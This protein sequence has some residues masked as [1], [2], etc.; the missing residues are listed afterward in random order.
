M[1]CHNK[2]F[3][4]CF[5]D[6][7]CSVRVDYAMTYIIAPSTIY[8]LASGPLVDARLQ[9]DH[10]I[11]IP[12]MLKLAIWKKQTPMIGLGKHIW[13]SVHIDDST[14]VLTFCSYLV[15][16]QLYS[17]GIHTAQRSVCTYCYSTGSSQGPQTW[18]TGAKEYTLLRMASTRDL[19][20]VRP[21]A[22]RS[23]NAGLFL[24]RSQQRSLH[25][26]SLP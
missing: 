16:E 14:S 18:D 2:P 24:V 1:V 25:R 8:G 19:K 12:G 7:P 17:G 13:P 6:T 9:N 26:N 20:S 11:Q 4:S 22:R 15:I 10:S 21:W 23:S 5:S 3:A